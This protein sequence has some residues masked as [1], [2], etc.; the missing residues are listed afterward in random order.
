MTEL[1]VLIVAVCLTALF[2]VL[3]GA[4]IASSL[5]TIADELRRLNDRLERTQ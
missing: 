2:S 3:A 1:V 4:S 5:G